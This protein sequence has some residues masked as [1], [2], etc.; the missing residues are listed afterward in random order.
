MRPLDWLCPLATTTPHSA[1]PGS[2]SSPRELDKQG[3]DSRLVCSPLG[4][5]SNLIPQSYRATSNPHSTP[6]GCILPSDLPQGHP[7]T[8]EY[9]HSTYSIPNPTKA[10]S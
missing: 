3:H 10:Q 6:L 7:G 2:Q 1:V 5:F 9:L 8:E 4:S